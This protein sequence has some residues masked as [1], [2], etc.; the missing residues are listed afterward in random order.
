MAL[1][2]EDKLPAIFFNFSKKQCNNLRDK[3]LKTGNSLLTKEEKE[4]ASEIIKKHVEKGGFFGTNENPASLLS[5]VALHHAGKMPA[6][7]AL[8]EEL[9]QKKLLKVV[10][11]TSTLGAGINVPAKTV[12]FT[13][14]T[15]YAGQHGGQ[16][17]E[18]FVTL[19]PSEFAQMAGR[20]GRR[21]KD[22]IGNVIVIPD[23]EHG[24]NCIYNLA[25]SK[26][27]AINSNFK[28]TYSFISHFILI[29]KLIQ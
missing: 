16:N 3:Y 15:R 7:K 28:P 4:L 14:L 18:R 10:F 17:G 5:G 9:A 21:G 13:Q 26:P 20:A 23:R 1:N 27:D 11:A 12:V 8:V 29:Y 2:K 25:T 22:F 24:A 6:Y 19:S